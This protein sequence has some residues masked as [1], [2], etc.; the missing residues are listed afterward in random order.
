MLFHELLNKDPYIVSEESPRI[1]L[2]SKSA[3]CMAENGKG[4]KR[5][6]HI[7]KTVH[8]VWNFK[9]MQHAKN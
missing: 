3:V 7:A 6:R 8:F 2:D 1:I 4:S 5:T 9:E